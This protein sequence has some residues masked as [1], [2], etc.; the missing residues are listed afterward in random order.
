MSRSLEEA[1][2]VL[3]VAANSDP[4]T[5]ARAY[6]RLARAT[7]PDVSPEPDAAQRFAAVA[8]AYRLVCDRARQAP[9]AGSDHGGSHEPAE[10]AGPAAFLS[11]WLA[12]NKSS[13]ECRA[14]GRSTKTTTD[15]R[16]PFLSPGLKASPFGP[17]QARTG[18]VIVAGPVMVQ[19]LRTDPTPGAPRTGDV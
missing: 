19:A 6:R 17:G 13:S 11:P 18:A 10:T 3:G 9:R 12:S 8:A 16:I 2:S 7:H 5:V 14:D 1:L 4:E 15:E